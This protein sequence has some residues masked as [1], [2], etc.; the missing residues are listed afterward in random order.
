VELDGTEKVEDRDAYRLKLTL[1]SG[2][3]L[4]VWVDAH[5]FLELKAEGQPRR[6]D[7]VEH[8]VEVY[9]HDYRIESGLMIPHT[10][11]THVASVPR[12][13]LGMRDTPIPPESAVI[14]KVVVN[15]KLEDALFT[16]PGI[17]MASALK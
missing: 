17:V 12:N 9:Y 1:R 10:L 11:E 16:K 3:S 13:A 14:E 5:S 8:R 15:P 6:L 2:A 7:G 4:H